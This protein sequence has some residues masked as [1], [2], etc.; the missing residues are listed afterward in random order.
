MV[1]AVHDFEVEWF[2]TH[3]FHTEV[4]H[5]L[6]EEVYRFKY[7]YIYVGAYPIQQTNA[8]IGAIASCPVG[9]FCLTHFFPYLPQFLAYCCIYFIVYYQPHTSIIISQLIVMLFL[10]YFLWSSLAPVFP[11][12]GSN[13]LKP[14]SAHSLV[15]SLCSDLY[16]SW[17][18]EGPPSGRGVVLMGFGII[19][20][21]VWRL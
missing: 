8:A 17:I 2:A 5:H 7:A 14:L 18:D 15:H 11:P 21:T 12:G 6:S 4:E 16:G 1:H 13:R 10:E 9:E 20:V 3:E 19:R